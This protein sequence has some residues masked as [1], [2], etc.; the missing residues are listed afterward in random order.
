MSGINSEIRE[1]LLTVAAISS[2]LLFIISEWLGLSKRF[3]EASVVGALYA[4]SPGTTPNHSRTSTSS[5]LPEFL[6]DNDASPSPLVKTLRSHVS[7]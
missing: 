2:T 6:D 3:R 7:S 4:L 5:T 1:I